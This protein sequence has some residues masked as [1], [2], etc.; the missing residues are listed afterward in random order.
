MMKFLSQ[1]LTCLTMAT[2]VVC[3]NSADLSLVVQTENG[4][5]AGAVRN[6]A[7]EF[8]G[9]PF[10]AAPVGDLRWELPQPAKP[11]IGVRDASA[12]GS[13]CPQQAR[14]NLTDESLNEDCLFVNVS[15]PADIKPNEKL[16][17][18][19]WIHGGAYVGGA[20]S[21]YR[22]D[23]LASQGRIVVVSTNYRLGVLGFMAHPAFAQANGVNGNYGLEDQRAAM[24]WVQR[25][26]SAF[27][28]DPTKVTI[29]GESAG[30]GSVCA[31]I[32]SPEHVEGLFSKAIILSG[33]CLQ[34]LISITDAEKVGTI[35]SDTV[36]CKGSKAEIVACMRNDKAQ[37]SVT[38]L[39]KAQGDYSV[40]HP[41]DLMPF[42]MVAGTPENPNFTFPR[43]SRL[44]METGKLVAVPLLMG[45][46]RN[47]LRLYV[48]YWWQEGKNGNALFPPIN[49]QTFGGWLSKLYPGKPANGDKT[50]AQL[51]QA[52]YTP[53]AGWPN[54]KA[55]PET[56][57]TILSDFIP[58]AG[59]NN[60]LFLRFG[61]GLNTY[62]NK[63]KKIPL[64][65]FEFADANALVNGVGIAKPYPEFSMGAVHSSALNYFFPGYSNN[66]KINA[67]DLQPESRELAKTMVHSWSNF[68]KTGVPDAQWPQY[69][70]GKKVML[71]EPGNV[72]LYNAAAQHKCAFWDG[73]YPQP[74]SFK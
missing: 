24:R 34:N 37:A 36:G 29:A 26:I 13:A 40:N 56:L 41:V 16:P 31:H 30:A 42:S 17:V 32:S 14:F 15:V 59:I 28:G 3:A 55:V 50:Y 48:G 8:R 6:G 66:S 49:A 47:E 12:F 65:E 33:G 45:G 39:L 35:I 22:L 21:L 58:P 57:G 9:L 46:A 67:P 43:T 38:N 10:A 20:S 52:E 11:W 71:W 7:K 68:V 53:V 2:T 64:Y 19:F 72:G 60:C 5:V 44:A 51:I 25:N 74:S 69:G 1:L 54:E 61:D 4:K 63:F 27:G 70:K 73:L 62:S 18:L 23:K